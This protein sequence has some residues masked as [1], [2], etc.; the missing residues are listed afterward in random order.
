MKAM[1][2]SLNE[3]SPHFFQNQSCQLSVPLL[4]SLLP[5][6]LLASLLPVHLNRVYF[7][8]ERNVSK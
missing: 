7:P 8:E 1:L 6:P 4:A 3:I 5:V 2:N